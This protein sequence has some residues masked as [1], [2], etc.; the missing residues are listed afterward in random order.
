MLLRPSCRL[1]HL[2]LLASS[3]R[4]LYTPT[5]PSR[6]LNQSRLFATMSSNGD[7]ILSTVTPEN[8][9]LEIKHPVDPTALEQA[10][11][12]LSELRPSGGGKVDEDKLLEVGKRLGDLK[13][14]PVLVS[15]EACKQAYEGLDETQRKAL[16]NIHA[17]VKIFAEAQRKAV[18]DTEIDIPGG[19]AGHTVSPCRGELSGLVSR[20]VCP[21]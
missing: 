7:R 2:T 10:K 17:R 13:E 18:V 15:P 4:A 12:I 5:V 16:T 1:L 8:V 9:S 3:S 14:G 20:F 19:K 6:F 11:A 21:A